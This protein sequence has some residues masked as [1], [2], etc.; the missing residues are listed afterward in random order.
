MQDAVVERSVSILP[1]PTTSEDFTLINSAFVFCLIWG[2]IVLGRPKVIVGSDD[3]YPASQAVCDYLQSKNFEVVKV[4]ALVTGKVESWVDVATEVAKGVVSGEFIFGVVVCYTGT[5]VSIAANK[6]KGARAALCPDAKT[7]EGAR[8]W[9]DANILAMSGR[10]VTPEL[11]K[12]ILD[13]WLLTS[14]VDPT[15]AENIAKLKALDECEGGD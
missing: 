10:L 8:K 12:E 5:G 15:E 1:S 3:V 13:A 7:A 6:V 2:V 9:N 11:A 4:G 14:K